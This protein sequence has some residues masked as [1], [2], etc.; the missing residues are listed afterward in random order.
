MRYGRLEV[1]AE[2]KKSGRTYFDCICD[3]GARRLVR[4]DNVR[5]GFTGSCGCLNREASSTR[6]KKLHAGTKVS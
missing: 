1:L 4:A 2:Q 3:C 6:L 5:A